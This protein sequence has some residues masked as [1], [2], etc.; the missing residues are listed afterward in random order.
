MALLYKLYNWRD[1]SDLLNI[2]N[3]NIR[4]NMGFL[5]GLTNASFKT[6]EK[7]NT[8]FYPLWI[9]GKGYIV[10]DDRK[11]WFRLTIKR[12]LIICIPLVI[13]VSMFLSLPLFFFII[14]PL[15]FCGCTIWMKKSTRGL[16]ISSSKLTLSDST[17]KSARSYNWN[18]FLFLEIISFLFVL[19]SIFILSHILSEWVKN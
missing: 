3:V 10:P 11:D 17:G 12:L 1:W 2:F 16:A 5:D 9:F 4:Y 6:N 7:G 14:L 13:T 15:Y 19:A 8:I 18:T